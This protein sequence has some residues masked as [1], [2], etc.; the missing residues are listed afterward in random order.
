MSYIIVPPRVRR[1][2]IRAPIAGKWSS[3][4]SSLWDGTGFDAGGVANLVPS[5]AQ[6]VKTWGPNGPQLTTTATDNW[7]VP[8]HPLY[9]F[10][11][12][13]FAFVLGVTTQHTSG[14]AVFAGCS[15]TAGENWWLGC[16]SGYWAVTLS[17]GTTTSATVHG[18]FANNAGRSRLVIVTRSNNLLSLYVDGQLEDSDTNISSVSPTGSLRLGRFG[19]YGSGYSVAADF[20]LAASMRRGLSPGQVEEISADPFS[21][22]ERAPRFVYYGT[23]EAGPATGTLA[24]TDGADSADLTGVSSGDITGNLAATDGADSAALLGSS[25]V[26]EIYDRVD[27]TETVTGANIMVLVPNAYSANPYNAGTPTNVILYVHGTGE[28]DDA[29]LDDAYK[30]TCRTALL[31]AGYIMGGVNDGGWGTD[32]SIN[33]Y[34][35]LE[36]YIRANYNVA[37]VALWSQSMGGL[38]GL[39]VLARNK[40]PGIVGWLGTYPLCSLTA[41]YNGTNGTNFSS[42]INSA[43]SITGVGI[44]TFANKCY[45]HDATLMNPLAFRNVP[46]RFYASAADTVVGDVENSIAMAALVASS[47]RE[48]TVVTCSGEHGHSSHFVPSEYVA[49]FQRCFANPIATSGIVFDQPV[50]TKTVTVTL[51]NESG[52]AQGSLS[53]LKW[54]FW[55]EVTPNLLTHPVDQG[56]TETTDGSGVLTITVHTTLSAGGVGW[57]VVTNSDGTT[58]QAHRAFSGP[59]AV[60]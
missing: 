22:Y 55:D 42:Y 32:T 33:C 8:T 38:S 57:L 12:G 18:N 2:P 49:F 37:N 3:Y 28:D 60:A 24:A 36:K 21:L 5:G 31:D 45:G 58:T 26:V 9:K 30:A 23:S 46:M 54:A 47:A 10:G 27:A 25:G 56:S 16:L 52:S 51:V 44:S 11:T 39:I 6:A 40:I 53:S 34:S 59:V 43:Y 14:T 20:W 1:S 4:A 19:D 17:G 7:G 35:G 50:A 41:A 15:A 29:L 48:S 13:D